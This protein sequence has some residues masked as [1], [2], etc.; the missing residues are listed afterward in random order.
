MTRN[1]QSPLPCPTEDQIQ[2]AL[3]MVALHR[4]KQY[5]VGEDRAALC[6]AAIILA[7]AWSKRADQPR[8]EAE[9]KK[10][11]WIEWAKKKMSQFEND[12]A[13]HM[14]ECHLEGMIDGD[15]PNP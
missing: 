7:D 15:G 4:D 10:D 8:G 9:A 5:P 6:H 12:I 2:A 11:A 14:V 3:E 13:E 1:D